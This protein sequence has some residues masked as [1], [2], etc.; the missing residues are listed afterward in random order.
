L[1]FQILS[2]LTPAICL[3]FIALAH[4]DPST[5][6]T[7]L[8]QDLFFTQIMGHMKLFQAINT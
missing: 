5:S 2:R 3:N 1:Q 6:Q 7:V 8:S 4:L